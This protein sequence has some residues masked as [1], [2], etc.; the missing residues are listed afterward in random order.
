M[1]KSR[2][3]R[4]P[5]IGLKE[6]IEKVGQIYENDYQNRVPKKVIAEH[7][8]Y[9]SLNGK[10]LGVIGALS[11]YG[12]LEGRGDET[13]VSDL[14]LTIIAH[15]PGSPERLT[16]IREA[17]E[18]PEL[19]SELDGKFPDGKA[20]DSAIRSYLLTQ[21][22]IPEAADNVVRSYRE[23]KMLVADEMSGYAEV[24]IEE[25]EPGMQ[26]A[27]VAGRQQPPATSPSRRPGVERAEF[28]L[29]SGLVIMEMPSEF[30]KKDF[31]LFKAWLELIK[32]KADPS[33]SQL[34]ADTDAR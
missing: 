2:S 1:A 25:D 21:K 31:D 30:S 33:S 7:M 18:K 26:P 34:D 6:A 15:E 16:A 4:Y 32:Q 8:G 13:G 22:F 10:S 28:P 11:R 23:T 14:A 3:P 24:E 19:F 29:R 20:S 12:L 27:P 5:A 17:A 9:G